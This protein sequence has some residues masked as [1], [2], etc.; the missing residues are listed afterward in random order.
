ML[1]SILKNF[2]LFNEG[3][4]LMGVAEEIGLPKLA[5]KMEE[6]QGGGMPAPVDIDMGNEKIE[7]DWTCAGFHADVVT[8]YGAS[9][10]NAKLLR[11]AGAYQRD[12]TGEVQAVEIVVR[13]RHKEID[14]GNAKVGSKSET[15]IKTTCSYYKLTVDG[16]VLFEIDALAMIYNVNGTDMLAEQRKAI[17]LA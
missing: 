4:S 6:Y 17:G 2:N 1:P 14:F 3:N 12:D 8:G 9:K 15:K 13:G 16:K 11:F 5:R 10:P 7:F